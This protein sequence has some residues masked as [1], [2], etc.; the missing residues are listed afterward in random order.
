MRRAVVVTVVAALFS[1]AA[2]T[3]HAQ[4]FPPPPQGD[5]NTSICHGRAAHRADNG[6]LIGYRPRTHYLSSIR[7]DGTGLRRVTKP[8]SGYGDFESE[9][10]ARYRE[11]RCLSGFPRFPR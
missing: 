3:A 10:G 4:Q 7:P 2:A 8:P 11:G 1:T 5:L 6:R 9:R